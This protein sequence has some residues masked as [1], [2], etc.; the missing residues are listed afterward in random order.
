TNTEQGKI[1]VK[2]ELDSTTP[3]DAKFDFT[4]DVATGGTPLGDGE[5]KSVTVTDFTKTYSSTESAKEGWDLTDITC[6]G[7]Q[8][9]TNTSSGDKTTR[10]ATFNVQPGED[11]TCTFTN[12]EQGKITVKKELDSTTP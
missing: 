6:T 11:I 8:G 3:G 9:T 5:S 2:K 12:T 10:R 7:D 4:G 1:T